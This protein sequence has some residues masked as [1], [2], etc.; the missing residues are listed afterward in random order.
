MTFDRVT[1]EGRLVRLEPLAAGHKEQ[2]CDAIRDGEL[3]K[4]RV[5]LV[6]HP[7]DIDAFMRDAK[8]AH[9]NGDGL[10][11]ATVSRATGRVVG[12]T[13]FM[14]ADVLN[15]RVEI[16]FTFLGSAWQGTGFNTEAKLMMLTHAFETLAMNRVELLTDFL[17]ERSR[18]AIL[19]LKAKEEGVLRNH[20][21]MRDG[22]V[23]DS[24]VYSIIRGEWP[25]VRQH[26]AA[27]LSAH[28]VAR[29]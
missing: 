5:T 9:E 8:M 19:G 18:R 13:R 12:S 24:V 4:L 22:R 26:L 11:F 7:N 10:T 6:P 25:A 23:R 21:I 1:L 28:A 20:M 29:R 14:N 3:W 27:K 15:R 17:N 16:G 2:L